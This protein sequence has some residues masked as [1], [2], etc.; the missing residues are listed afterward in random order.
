MI[1]GLVGS[2]SLW[3]KNVVF[4]IVLAFNMGHID[5]YLLGY[6]ASECYDANCS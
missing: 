5:K 6:D 3:D 4:T 2:E 1:D